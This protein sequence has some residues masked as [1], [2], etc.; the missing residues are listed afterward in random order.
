MGDKHP[1]T[2]LFVGARRLLPGAEQKST[3]I[4][5][6]R[7]IEDSVD[8][9]VSTWRHRADKPPANRPHTRRTPSAKVDSITLHL[10]RDHPMKALSVQ[11]PWTQLLLS[12]PKQFD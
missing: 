10:R 2:D 5:G 9:T 8:L 3:I 1:A 12:G 4:H 7:E 6:S 11:Q